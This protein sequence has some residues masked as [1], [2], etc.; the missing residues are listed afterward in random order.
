MVPDVFCADVGVRSNVTMKLRMKH[1]HRSFMGP[2]SQA[3]GRAS[4]S[5]GLALSVCEKHTPKE[6]LI[7]L[8]LSTEDIDRV[9]SA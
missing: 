3:A 2:P 6:T 8:S 7:K 4:K 1:L 9:A 5:C